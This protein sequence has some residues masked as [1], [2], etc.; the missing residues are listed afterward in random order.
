MFLRNYKKFLVDTRQCSTP[1]P[2]TENLVKDLIKEFDHN[3]KFNPQLMYF[4]EQRIVPGVL[5]TKHI[6]NTINIIY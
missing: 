5:V 4:L 6:C 3:K 1:L 2:L